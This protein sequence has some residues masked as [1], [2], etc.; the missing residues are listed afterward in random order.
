MLPRIATP[1]IA[2]AALPAQETPTGG[3]R[4]A[5]AEAPDGKG[6]TFLLTMP[7]GYRSRFAA[8]GFEYHTCHEEIFLLDGLLHFGDWYDYRALGYLNHP[9]YWLH[10]ADQKTS[11]GAR[12]LIKIDKPVDFGFR[13]IPDDWDGA[14]VYDPAAPIIPAGRPI[15]QVWLDG[16]PWGAIRFRDGAPTGLY[17][18]RVWDDPESGWTTW[19]MRAPA[20]WRNTAPAAEHTGGDELY[21]L[22]GDWSVPWHPEPLRGETYY[23]SPD[24]L[25][26]GGEHT[27]GGMIAIRWTKDAPYHL[28]PLRF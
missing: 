11:T 9:P 22:S 26:I 1:P 19:L 7:P 10:P 21:L 15:S 4:V 16:V 3:S 20:G 24:L 6:K 2:I 5:I 17:G 27:D 12:M 28:P 13:P 23:C 25:R 14:E 8:E 18:K